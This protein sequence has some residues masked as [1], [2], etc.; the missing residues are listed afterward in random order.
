MY[1]NKDE[2]HNY[3]LFKIISDIFY[4]VSEIGLLTCMGY[5]DEITNF[6]IIMEKYFTCST[7][8]IYKPYL[9]GDYDNWC[10]KINICG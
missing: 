10:R 7:D 3:E 9:L 5:L 1:F 6:D 4:K 2:E 8:D